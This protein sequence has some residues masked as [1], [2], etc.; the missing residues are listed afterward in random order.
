MVCLVAMALC[1]IS[2]IQTLIFS[3]ILDFH[4]CLKDLSMPE[5]E[6]SLYADLTVDWPFFDQS[7]ADYHFLT[8][9]MLVNKYW[10]I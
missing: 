8:N 3:G 9:P 6:K 2:H 5:L 7:H 4:K 1:Q 10:L